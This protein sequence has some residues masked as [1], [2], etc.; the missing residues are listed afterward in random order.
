VPVS[1]PVVYEG[2]A[3]HARRIP[4]RREFAPRLFLAYLDVDALPGTLDGVPGWSARRRA[5]VR[6]R[7]EDFF[8]GDGRPLGDGV[9]DLVQQRLGRRPGGPVFLLAQLRTWGYVFNPLSAYYCW[10]RSGEALDAVVLE[11]TNTPWGERHWYVFDARDA[12]TATA[13]KA[14]YVSPFLPMDVD[15]RVSWTSPG[16]A[17][18]L[19]V[20]VERHGTTLFAAGLSMR[21][22]PLT[23]RSA[24]GL[25]V[26]YPMLPAQGIVGIYRRALA[27]WIRRVPLHRHVRSV[28]RE[29]SV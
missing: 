18:A 16:E 24:L 20:R 19:E 6:F 14:M 2:T 1:R 12:G 7:A 3:R 17:L 23:R 5:P 4:T 21:R 15:Y 13:T 22:A 27:L 10:N 26:R 9:R 8:T 28:P 11:V 29:V 25:L